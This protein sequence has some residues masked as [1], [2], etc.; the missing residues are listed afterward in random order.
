MFPEPAK[1]QLSK[2]FKTDKSKPAEKAPKV[3]EKSQA[4][5]SNAEFERRLAKKLR[6]EQKQKVRL[7]QGGYCL[8]LSVFLGYASILL[9]CFAVTRRG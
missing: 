1:K 2:T 3:A 7:L 5:A 4:I 6:K 8:F 9:T